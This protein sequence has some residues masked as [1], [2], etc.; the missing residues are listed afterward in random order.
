M[1]ALLLLLKPFLPYIIGAVTILVGGTSYVWNAKRKAK[2]EG[3]AQQQAKESAANAQDIT[4][5]SA[6]LALV[7][8]AGC[9]QTLTTAITPKGKVPNVCLLWKPQTYSA[10]TDSPETVAE[11]RQRNAEREIYCQKRT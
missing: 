5:F 4:S 9:S 1:T 8:L 7:L 3:I 6:L 10:K 11:I 2:N